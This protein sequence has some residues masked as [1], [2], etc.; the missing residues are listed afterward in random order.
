MFCTRSHSGTVV[1][2]PTSGWRFKPRT[3]CGKVCICLPVV[4]SLQNLDQLYVLVSSAPKTMQ[5]DIAHS[6]ESDVKTQINKACNINE[7]FYVSD[8]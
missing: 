8:M 4:G 3:L 5:H 1:T 2:P 6:V 7:R